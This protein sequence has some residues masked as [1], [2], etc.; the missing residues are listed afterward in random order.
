[1]PGPLAVRRC[2][3]TYFSR[4]R[5]AR[6]C[7]HVVELVVEDRPRVEQHA[8]VVDP[9]EH[10]RVGRP[11]RSALSSA[12][13]PPRSRAR[14]P[15]PRA[16]AAAARRPRPWRLRGH[17][18]GLADAGG[19]RSRA[20]LERS[21]PTSSIA[22]SGISRRARSGSRYSRSVASSAASDSLSIRIARASG[23][24]RAAA[25]AVAR[26]RPRAPPAG[27]RAA[28]R[29][30]STRATHPPSASARS[31]A[32]RRARAAPRHRPARP[33]RRRRSPA[34]RARTAPRSR[35]PRRTR[36]R[37]SSTGARG[38]SRRPRRRWAASARS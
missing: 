15:A 7:D 27:R 1:M 28:C 12:R 31:R 6:G 8:A 26:F 34:R 20:G 17:C 21:S 35:P 16:R 36:R 30:N 2:F 23:C 3:G 4:S 38:G 13:V 14:R 18:L 33:S 19:D 11:Q 32:R 24:R 10:R 22:S 9:G 5:A 25:T 29:P 37:G